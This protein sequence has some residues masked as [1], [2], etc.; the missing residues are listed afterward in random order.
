MRQPRSERQQGANVVALKV[1]S[2][3]QDIFDAHASGVPF[4]HGFDR[5]AQAAKAGFAVRDELERRL[6]AQGLRAQDRFGVRY[7]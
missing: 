6:S 7:P 3:G 1:G 2:F 5:I 4:V